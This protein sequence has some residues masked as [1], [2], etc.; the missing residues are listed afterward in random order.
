MDQDWTRFIGKLALSFV[1]ACLLQHF[2]FCFKLEPVERRRKLARLMQEHL[3]TFSS[4]MTYEIKDAWKEKD[5]W[6]EDIEIAGGSLLR[7]ATAFV[8]VD[9]SQKTNRSSSKISVS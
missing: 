7:V 8:V 5:H 9:S 2:L 3:R 1:L 6:A 4:A